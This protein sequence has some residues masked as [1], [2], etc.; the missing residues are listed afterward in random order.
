MLPVHPV[1]TQRHRRLLTLDLRPP[2][3]IF[4]NIPVAF[5]AVK[6]GITP[7]CSIVLT[8]DCK[9]RLAHTV[10]DLHAFA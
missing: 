4:R 9:P 6:A 10:L 3:G 2:L 8:A 7:P 5:A 1:L